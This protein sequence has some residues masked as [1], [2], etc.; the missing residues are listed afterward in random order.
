MNVYRDSRLWRPLEAED[1]QLIKADH[2][3]EMLNALS[4]FQRHAMSEVNGL[5]GLQDQV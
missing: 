3:I 4:L 5:W 1:G 2:D